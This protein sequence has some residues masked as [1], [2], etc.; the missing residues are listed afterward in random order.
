[1]SHNF[2]VPTP[3]EDSTDT[4]GKHK[5]NRTKKRHFVNYKEKL[6]RGKKMKK[7]RKRRETLNYLDLEGE[8]ARNILMLFYVTEFR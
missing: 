1:M 7:N 2:H 6:C 4:I 8:E 5:D 3:A